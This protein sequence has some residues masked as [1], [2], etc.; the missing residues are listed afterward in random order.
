MAKQKSRAVL[1]Q[2]SDTDLRLLRVFKSVA[3]CGGMAAAELDLNIGISTISRHLKDLETR[4]G[5]VLCRRGRGGF[6]LTAEGERVY[7]ETLRLLLSVDMFR[8][9]IDDIHQRMGG[10]LEIALF[11]KTATN[12]H[13]RI[14]QAIALFSERAPAVALNVHIGSISV[15]ERGIMDG[16]LHVGVI[17][18]HRS[19]GMLRY[20]LLFDEQMLLYCGETHPL[21][22]ANHKQ[23]TWAK[24]KAHA[25]AGLGYHSPNMEVS[26]RARLVRSATGFD[27]EAIATLILS[28]R[29][30]GFLPDHYAASFESTGR[31]RPI[32]R[33]KFNYVCAFVSLLRRSPEPSRAAA[34]FNECL[35]EAH[36]REDGETFPPS[37]G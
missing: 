12:P 27:Q 37:P 25:F 4:L 30:L 31:M 17:P 26:N 28:G 2:V 29:F 33:E 24:L 36:V 6:A 34:L 15:I 5:L 20:E 14:H 23:L 11:D 16:S 19:S 22:R 18:A 1:G 3:D 35:I 10:R 7:E 32:L 9:G 21:F 13:S 8:G